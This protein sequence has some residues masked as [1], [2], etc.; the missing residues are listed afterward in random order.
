MALATFAQMAARR[1]GGIEPSDEVRAEANLDDASAFVLDL[2]D[3]DT[4]TAWNAS[5]PALVVAVVC[6]AA[7]RG[8][9]NP[10]GVRVESQGDYRMELESASGVYLTEQ[11]AKTVRKLAG[12][13]GAASIETKHPYGFTYELYGSLDYLRDKLAL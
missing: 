5:P 6:R 2:V 12:F 11:E 13:P 7:L 8:F 9:D 1:P 3:D 4:Q 10:D